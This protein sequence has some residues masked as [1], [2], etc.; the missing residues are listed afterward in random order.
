MSNQ[1]T[2]ATP[3]NSP[4]W[5]EHG[6][7]H[8]DA[9]SE[10]RQEFLIEL[11]RAQER[12]LSLSRTAAGLQTLL[13]P[14]RVL[15]TIGTEL[16]DQGLLCFFALPDEAR[17]HLVLRYTNLTDQQLHAVRRLIGRSLIG[18]RFP[19]NSTP[20]LKA[21]LREAQTVFENDVTRSI[22]E[23]LPGSSEELAALLTEILAAR[24]AISAP[25]VAGTDVLGLLVVCADHLTEADVPLISV[26]A[27]QAAA[28]MERAKLYGDAMERVFE[29][30]ALR[31]T[32]L[33]MTRQ[34][35]P[36]QLLRLIVER[37]AALIGTKG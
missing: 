32:T 23:V 2:G 13:D 9:H 7:S 8:V 22:H 37:A 14:N 30:D 5:D 12:I 20:A 16:R 27:Q 17:D 26:V 24:R 36:A 1:S 19:V 3:I 28:A 31:M 10:E 29:M 18:L 34:L 4:G 11:Q 21:V 33:D 25:L 35:D 6:A 15:E